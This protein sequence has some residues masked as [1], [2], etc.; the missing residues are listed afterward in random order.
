MAAQFQEVISYF[1]YTIHAYHKDRQLYISKLCL[2]G[3]H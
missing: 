2:D 3:V 1:N